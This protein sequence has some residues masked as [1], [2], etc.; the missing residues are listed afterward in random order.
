MGEQPDKHEEAC[1]LHRACSCKGAPVY[2]GH[3]WWGSNLQ[4]LWDGGWNSAA[5]HL[6]LRGVGWTALWCLWEA[7]CRT[8]RHKHSLSKGPLPLHMRRR[9][10]ESVLNEILGLHNKPKAAVHLVHK[11]T[12]PKKK[13]MR[14]LVVTFHNFVNVPKDC[15]HNWGHYL[16]RWKHCSS[17]TCNTVKFILVFSWKY[18]V[19]YSAMLRNSFHCQEVLM[20]FHF[21]CTLC[22]CSVILLTSNDTV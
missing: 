10:I 18:F 1:D 22:L 3:V 21:H 7:D 2:C 17:L 13:N 19:S 12:G 14:R 16:G 9:V 5:H 8:K 15:T 11:L 4:F 20:V 6:L